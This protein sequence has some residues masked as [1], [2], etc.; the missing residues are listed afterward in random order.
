MTRPPRH[1]FRFSDWNS[2]R[3]LL[4]TPRLFVLYFAAFGVN[5]SARIWA[6]KLDVD[7]YSRN[8]V[9]QKALIKIA[10]V[11]AAGHIATKVVVP[12]P[13]VVSTTSKVVVDMVWSKDPEALFFVERAEMLL[14]QHGQSAVEAVLTDSNAMVALSEGGQAMVLFPLD[15][16]P[17][18]EHVAEVTLEITQRAR[19]ELGASRIRMHLTGRLS[20]R[21]RIEL[22]TQGWAL[23]EGVPAGSPPDQ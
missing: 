16:V 13:T 21:A 17:W 15:Y 6:K 4:S 8:P 1:L 22:E 10:Q 2:E 12:I 9:L 3:K 5:K 18:T 11:D 20:E 23:D 14:R 19:E 7:P